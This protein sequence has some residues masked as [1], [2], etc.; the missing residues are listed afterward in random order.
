MEYSIYKYLD[1]DDIGRNHIQMLPVP[2]Q[3]R[4]DGCSLKRKADVQDRLIDTA[5]VYVQ[6]EVK[7]NKEWWVCLSDSMPLKF[8]YATD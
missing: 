5:L 3:L 4:V 1:Y 2:Y 8:K 7:D 6:M